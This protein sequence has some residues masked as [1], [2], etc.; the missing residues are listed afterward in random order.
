MKRP[1]FLLVFSFFFTLCLAQER[2]ENIAESFTKVKVS[3]G[4]IA[5]IHVNSEVNKVVVDGLDKNEVDIRFRKDELRISLP[6]NHLFS[7]SD[8]K[9]DIYV[10]TLE[11]LEATSSAELNVEGKIKQKE[12]FFKVVE[13]AK[14]NA[15]IEVDKLNLHL[16]TGGIITLNGSAHQQDI[17]IK[18]GA[19][20]YGE[21]LKTNITNVEVSY[22][23][24]AE[25]F[26]HESCVASVIAGGEVS[27][28]GEPDIFDESTKLG[29]F[30]KR[31]VVNK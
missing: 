22:K 18:T 19:E 14:I 28:F 23:G 1:T 5:T 13:M 16:L 3:S 8:T 20:Y 7:N 27:V 6:L 4:I 9:V 2:V 17:V 31:V 24:I 26:A 12:I 11:I 30:I 21:F 15:S 25:V 10:K 29:G